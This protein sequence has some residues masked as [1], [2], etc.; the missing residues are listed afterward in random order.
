V[1]IKYFDFDDSINEADVMETNRL[2]QNAWC[3]L[4]FLSHNTD[5]IDKSFADDVIPTINDTI[6]ECE[7]KINEAPTITPTTPNTATTTFNRTDCSGIT[8]SSDAD[9]VIDQL[10][11]VNGNISDLDTKTPNITIDDV[12]KIEWEVQVAK[13]LLNIVQYNTTISLSTGQNISNI[14]ENTITEIDQKIDDATPDN[15][16]NDDFDWTSGYMIAVYVLV[17][18]VLILIIVAGVCLKHYYNHNNNFQLDR[19]VADAAA[20]QNRNARRSSYDGRRGGG[21]QMTDRGHR[22]TNSRHEY[23]NRYR[24]QSRYVRNNIRETDIENG[25]EQPTFSRTRHEQ[26]PK[27][28]VRSPNNREYQ[29]SRP[30][31]DDE[32][33]RRWQK[34]VYNERKWQQASQNQANQRSQSHKNRTM[35]QMELSPRAGPSQRQPHSSPPRRT[36]TRNYS[37]SD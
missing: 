18:V 30:S 15:D 34:T 29:S 11:Y 5:Q 26:Y 35:N 20:Y 19:D 6:V 1:N 17:P 25:N 7:N 10:N 2:Y 16:N 32:D 33:E 22:R 23:D 21:M 36:H 31:S 24:D 13:C 3:T 37:S 9:Y 28:S 14:I 4:D 27:T 12:D 8:D